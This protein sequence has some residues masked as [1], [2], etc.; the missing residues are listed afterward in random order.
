[1]SHLILHRK[2]EFG[3]DFDAFEK[4]VE[5]AHDVASRVRTIIEAEHDAPFTWELLASLKKETARFDST[6]FLKQIYVKFARL[7]HSLNA[8]DR[9][10]RAHEE[11]TVIEEAIKQEAVAKVTAD[12]KA[13]LDTEAAAD[14]EAHR[15]RT[16]LARPTAPAAEPVQA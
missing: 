7:Q 1:M 2:S 4:E 14:R 15:I 5:A 11:S 3:A 10:I 6:A 16:L 8:I 12:A 9:E 13:A